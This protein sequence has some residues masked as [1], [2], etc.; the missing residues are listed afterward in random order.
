VLER[1]RE[2]ERDRVVHSSLKFLRVKEF[3]KKAKILSKKMEYVQCLLSMFL[4]GN[5]TWDVCEVRHYCVCSS[6]GQIQCLDSEE[7]AFEICGL[8]RPSP[9]G[10]T[11]VEP[12]AEE[13]RC[14][15]FC[16]NLHFFPR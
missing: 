13:V 3:R 15:F 9:S 2:R 12:E 16:I 5:S 10:S 4:W 14:Y 8:Y 6:D 1:E 7:E 11:T